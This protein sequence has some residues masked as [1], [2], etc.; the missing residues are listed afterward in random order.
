MKTMTFFDTEID[1]RSKKI[2]DI[3][4]VKSNGN[5]FYADSLIRFAEFLNDT[6]YIC[7][8]NIIRYD[9]VEK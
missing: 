5:T 4:A 8:H 7:G 9:L 6:E 1:H 2:M 3:G